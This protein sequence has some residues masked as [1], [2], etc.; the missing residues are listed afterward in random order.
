[1]KLVVG[2]GNPGKEYTHSRHNIG[3]LVIN[4]LAR[5]HD[6]TL[7]K[8][9]FKSRW[10]TGKISRHKVILAKPHTYMNLS[11]EA[12]NAITRFYKIVPKDIIVVHDD[13][14]IDFGHLKIKT[15]GGS[16]GHRGIDSIITLLKEDKFVRVRVGVGRPTSDIDPSDF[17]LKQFNEREKKDLK[18]VI[19]KAQKCIET[20]LKQGPE[21]AMNIFHRG[22]PNN[23][24]N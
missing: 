6:I 2:L 22:N 4:Q 3:F 12:V 16:G 20:I 5:S 8:R 9:K 17:V 1:M 11:G 15:K 24:L 14:D 10:E 19:T 7:T 13:I 18:E 21:S 23:S